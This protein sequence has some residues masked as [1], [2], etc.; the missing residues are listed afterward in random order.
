M[1]QSK[2]LMQVG[3]AL[4]VCLLALAPPVVSEQQPTKLAR[5][6]PSGGSV[7]WLPEVSAERL[8]LT[9]SGGEELIQQSFGR[10]EVPTVALQRDE[11][12]ALPDGVYSWE[13]REE[14]EPVN[15]GVYDPENGRDS[16]DP[17]SASQ[18]VPLKGRVQ[19]GTFTI[20]DGVVAAPDVA[21][22]SSRSESDE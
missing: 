7:M 21:E 12:G 16:V 11:G 3:A 5:M 1:R 13:L 10:G 18:R 4:A 22:P 6:T 14:F 8:A 2:T 17:S 19:S 15:D 20:R 9:V